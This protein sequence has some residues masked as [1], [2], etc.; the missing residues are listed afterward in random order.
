MIA[1]QQNG[2]FSRRADCA[3]P[4]LSRIQKSLRFVEEGGFKVAEFGHHII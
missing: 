2:P 4:A 1:P 3:R